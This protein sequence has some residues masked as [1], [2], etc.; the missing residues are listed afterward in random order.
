MSCQPGDAGQ[1]S[2]GQSAVGCHCTP[3]EAAERMRG[4]RDRTPAAPQGR[5]GAKGGLTD[6]F[7]LLLCSGLCS[8]R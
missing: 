2:D 6:C 3:C 1:H 4:Q 8:L 7:A 5:K